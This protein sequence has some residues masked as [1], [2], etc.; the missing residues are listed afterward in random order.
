M[1]VLR[2][3]QLRYFY[4]CMYVVAHHIDCTIPHYEAGR[5]TESIK[6]AF[7]E[8]YLFESTPVHKA[9]WRVATSCYGVEARS[10]YI[11]VRLY[12]HAYT[13]YEGTIFPEGVCLLL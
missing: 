6:K 3:L 4:V 9:L 2:M 11:Y 1:H 7:P 5:V 10:G 13:L 8:H 12:M